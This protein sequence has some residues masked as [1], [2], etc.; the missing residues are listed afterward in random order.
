M[1]QDHVTSH[2]QIHT[3]LRLTLYRHEQVKIQIPGSYKLR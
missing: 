2:I 3:N 1:Y